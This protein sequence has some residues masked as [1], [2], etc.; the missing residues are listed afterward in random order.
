MN[1]VDD[2]IF[3][4]CQKYN[5]TLDVLRGNRTGEDL[6][7]ARKEISVRLAELGI[8]QSGIGRIM[9]L[10][11]STVCRHLQDDTCN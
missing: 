6:P 11:P 8:S 2:V 5:C 7:K 1:T 10:D 4:V 3:D 9:H